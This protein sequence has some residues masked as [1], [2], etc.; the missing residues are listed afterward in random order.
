MKSVFLSLALALGA[1]QAH[2]AAAAAHQEAADQSAGEAWV[3]VYL[4]QLSNGEYSAALATASKVKPDA[5]NK[6]GRSFVAAMRAAALLGLK[7]DTEAKK[8]FSEADSLAPHSAFPSYLEFETALRINN[9]EVAAVALDRMISRMPDAV[10]EIDSDYMNYFL[11]NEPDGQDRA[12]E[13]RRV[14][15]ARLGYGGET[16]SGDHLAA[17]AV[18]ILMKRG[19]VAGVRE[20]L[21][22]IDEPQ[23]IE[24]LLILKR[25]AVLWPQIEGQVG[26]G[27]SKARAS[28]VASAKRYYD[29]K[30]G[31]HKRLHLLINALRHAGQLDEAIA[32]RSELPANSAEM[33]TADED[34]GWAVNNAALA[35]HEAGMA[36]Q[37][38]ELFAQLNNAPMPKEYWRV[39]MKIN[40]LELLVA[41]GKYAQAQPLVEPTATTEGSAY[42]DQLVRRLRYCTLHGLGRSAEAEKFY[43]EMMA[44]SD[45]AVGPTIDGLVCA[46]KLDEAEKLAL[47][48]LD[49]EDFQEG[50]VRSL[51][52]TA[53]TSDDPSIWTNGWKKLRERP[54]LAAKFQ[55]LG[56]DMPA[57]F[58]VPKR[59]TN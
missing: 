4:K 6:E 21:K 31:D 23:L 42:A 53:L 45:D 11:N 50:F 30:P 32:L 27:L 16:E 49:D 54:A 34:M 17:R 3:D 2:P 25:Y 55:E 12:N 51:Q 15:L 18:R 44:H 48:S 10:R 9:I 43:P 58:L 29:E 37:A 20:L 19:D 5:G 28:A 8:L 39:S 1:V 13:D 59:K 47:S 26:P 57:A 36:D 22:Y 24:N 33:S 41:D 56:R 40:R 52:A 14:A 38:D 46:G 7:R 35:L